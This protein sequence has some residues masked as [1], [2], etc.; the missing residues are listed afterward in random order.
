MS[1]STPVT[2]CISF[3]EQKKKK[4]R[5]DSTYYKKIEMTSPTLVD[6]KTSL[7]KKNGLLNVHVK[8]M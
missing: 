4:S 2:Y 5:P 6:T 1:F 3:S 7:A 8:F